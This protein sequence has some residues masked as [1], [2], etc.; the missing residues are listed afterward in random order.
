MEDILDII[1]SRRSVKKYKDTPVEFELIDKVVTAGMYAPSGMNKQSA[2]ILAVT[3]KQMRDKLSSMCAKCRGV[4]NFDPFYGA[5]VALVVLADKNVFTHV[6]DG[7]V[8]MENMLLEAHSLG[9]GACWI[10]W[11]KEMFESSEGKEILKN[12]GIEGEYEG[13][14]TC[15]LG[16]S[17]MNEF[18]PIDRKDHYVYYIK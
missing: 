12:L 17:D 2:I 7:S 9:L 13:V 6:Y 18:K 4:E 11:A 14:G 1:V 10:H 15:I 16:Y 8:V 3:N 5:P